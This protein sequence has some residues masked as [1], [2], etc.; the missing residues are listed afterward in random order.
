[1]ARDA[2]LRLAENG[3]EFADRELRRLQKAQNAQPGFLASGFEARKQGPEGERGRS[4][5]IRH[6]HIFISIGR[7]VKRNR[8]AGKGLPSGSL[9]ARGYLSGPPARAP[10]MELFSR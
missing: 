9:F 5:F 1:M 10:H 2:R 7:S 3:D 8:V 4:S 6:K